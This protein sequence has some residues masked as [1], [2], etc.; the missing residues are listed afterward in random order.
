MLE[1]RNGQQQKQQFN[2]EHVVKVAKNITV[3][4]ISHLAIYIEYTPLF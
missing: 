4:I 2:I 3:P 1:P